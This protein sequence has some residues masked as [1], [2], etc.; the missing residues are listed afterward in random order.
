MNN[1]AKNLNMKRKREEEE[2]EER[3]KERT[4]TQKVK[5]PYNWNQIITTASMVN[6]LTRI[7]K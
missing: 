6:V 5:T 3:K 4:R 7:R 2:E 1:D